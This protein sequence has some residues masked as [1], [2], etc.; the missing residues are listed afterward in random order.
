MDVL[1]IEGDK[2]MG[3]LLADTPD[4]ISFT[5]ALDNEALNLFALAW[6]TTNPSVSAATTAPCGWIAPGVWIGSSSQS[7]KSGPEVRSRD[8][9]S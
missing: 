4:G 5:V 7:D 2:Q 9:M 8:S 3:S 1:I 6:D